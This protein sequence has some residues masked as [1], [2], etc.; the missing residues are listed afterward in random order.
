[1]DVW[2]TQ[3]GTGQFYNLTQGAETDIANPSLRTLGFSP[4]GSL[5][6]YWRRVIDSAGTHISIWAA[7]VLGGPPRPY[8]DGVAE[9]RLVR[10]RHPPRVPHPRTRQS[11]V[12]TRCGA[13]RGAAHILHV[14]RAPRALPRLVAGSGIRLLRSFG[15]RGRSRAHGHLAHPAD[16]GTPERITNHDSRVTHPVFLDSRTLAYL[17]S[18]PDGS[19]PWLHSLDIRRRVP[20]RVSFGLESYT[21]L[22]ASADGQRLVAT[23]TNRKGAL[24]RFPI[25]GH[26]VRIDVGPPH[27]TD[28]RKR[29]LSQAWGRLPAVCLVER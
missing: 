11:H 8:L 13:S 28:H 2:V 17:A 4:D 16:G 29:I 18:D 20:H 5:V 15:G 27:L 9:V 12:R 25:D 14:A 21:S 24:W 6:T 1:M 26:P 3:V 10:R 19:G 23:L 7:P 22:A